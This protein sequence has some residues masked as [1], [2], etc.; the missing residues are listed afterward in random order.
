MAI[1][2]PLFAQNPPVAPPAPAIV[3]TPAGEMIQLQFPNNGIN[4]VLGIYE[5]LTSKAVVKESGIFDGKPISLVTATPVTQ[6][7]AV[8]LIES[9]RNA[10]RMRS[11][12]RPA[13][14]CV[15]FCAKAKRCRHPF[16]K[17]L[18]LSMTFTRR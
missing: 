18:R 13:P 9:W 4:D 14:G 3:P 12:V 7:E 11:S 15:I 5:L 2:I 1:A 8:E 10:S 16:E 6:R 17:R